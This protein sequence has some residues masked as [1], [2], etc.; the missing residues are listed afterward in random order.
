M[1]VKQVIQLESS[2]VTGQPITIPFEFSDLSSLPAGK[3]VG[4]NIVIRPITVRT[5]FKLKP[6]LIQ[7][8]SEDTDKLTVKKD[9][10]FDSSIEQLISKYDE[11]LFDIVCIGIHN[12]KGDM[13]D[14]F[15][16]VLKDNCT[17]ND[18]YILL[19]AIL[20][21]LNYNPFFNSIT[22]CKNVSPLSEEEIIALQKNQKTWNHKAVSCSSRSAAR[23]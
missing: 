12:K 13:P 8:D 7:I 15:K 14:W 16:D 2:A 4:D 21:R 19:N 10:E 17:W 23:R 1:S 11:L 3:K 20:F 22:L 5:W 18:I 9:I 6:L